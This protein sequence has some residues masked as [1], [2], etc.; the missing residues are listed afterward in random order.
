MSE[1]DSREL[2]ADSSEM[3]CEYVDSG[4]Q[5]LSFEPHR[6]VIRGVKLLGLRSQNG[7]RY[8]VAALRSAVSLYEGAKVNVN[9]PDRGPMAAR[10]YRDRLGV[11]RNVRLEA[12]SGL[13][14]DLHYN[15]K[16]ALAQQL[17]WDAEH[18]PQNVGLSHNVLAKT[19]RDGEGVLVEAITRVQSVDLVADPAT[20]S[21]LFEGRAAKVATDP[22]AGESDDLPDE[23]LEETN[24][25]L[26][27]Q[28]DQL[29][30]EQES[31]QRRE[32]LERLM[33]AHGVPQGAGEPV[34]TDV[35]LESLDRASD[36]DAARIIGDRARL[37][38]WARSRQGPV[39]KEQ[40]SPVVRRRDQATTSADFVRAITRK[41]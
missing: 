34:V 7:R 33:A 21:G 23:S 6:G 29:R 17:E 2:V 10:D 32:R 22:P 37:V 8:S 9:H 19:R 3:V 11:V 35:F 1:T 15:P 36:E 14:G 13:F 39:S 28:L 26:R 25:Q 18:T 20:T 40:P 4:G 41:Q 31:V 12:S 24:A 16:H 38:E 30:A 27:E 5:R